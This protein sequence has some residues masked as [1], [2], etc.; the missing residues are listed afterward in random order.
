MQWQNN[1]FLPGYMTIDVILLRQFLNSLPEATR[2]DLAATRREMLPEGRSLPR[3]FPETAKKAAVLALLFPKIPTHLLLIQRSTY[4]GVHSAQIS[5]PGGKP[6]ETENDLMQTALREMH[7]EIGLPPESISVLGSLSP[8]YIPVSQFLVYPFVGLCDL[9]NPTFT[10]QER[11][12]AAI[13]KI[14]LSE[15]L[16]PECKGFTAVGTKEAI[17]CYTWNTP[18]VWGATALILRELEEYLKLSAPNF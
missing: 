18:P 4:N 3:V 17:P 2:E 8:V 5:F 12:V 16:N 13:Y 15:I 1:L 10:A 9:E 11:E 14:P 6:L 7:E